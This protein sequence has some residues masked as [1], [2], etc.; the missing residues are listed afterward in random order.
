MQNT[1]FLVRLKRVG[2]NSPQYLLGISKSA[3]KTTSER[4]LALL[5]GK[6]TAQDAIDCIQSARCVG[7]LVPI[8]ITA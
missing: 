2:A 6:Y 4:K 7:E 3:I 1:K 5:M 8:K